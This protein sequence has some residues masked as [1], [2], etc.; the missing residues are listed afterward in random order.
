MFIDALKMIMRSVNEMMN[1]FDRESERVI[2]RE[3][4]K[5]EIAGF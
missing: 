1:A 4:V 2:S 5:A 3:K